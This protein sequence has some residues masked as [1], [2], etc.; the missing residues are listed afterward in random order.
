MT[1]FLHTADLH[2]NAQRRNF[3]HYLT[4]AEWLLNEIEDLATEQNCDCIVVA[5]DIFEQPNTTIAERQLLSDWLGRL[6]TPVLMI[7]GNHDARDKNIGNTCISYLSSLK[8]HLHLVHDG[9]PRIVN[10]FG[11]CWL[12]LPYHGWTD[13]EFRLIVRTM[14]WRIRRKQPDVPIV[15]ITHEAVKGAMT[16]RN[17]SIEKSDQ[18][19]LVPDLGPTY[20][21]LGDIHAPQQMLPN[22]YYCGAPYQVDFGEAAD[23]KGVLLVDTDDP[24]HPV[25]VDLDCPYPLMALHEPPAGTWPL[26]GYYTGEWVKTMP[27]HILYRPDAAEQRPEIE[28]QRSRV[29]LLH[30]LKEKLIEQHHPEDLLTATVEMG[31]AMAE[32][33]GYAT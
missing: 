12:L 20:W 2:L 4:R 23:Q 29:P 3:P 27:E 10:A 24:E 21:A 16:D 31:H 26:F 25:S 6:Q 28:I 30:R 22:A 7:S 15:A 8:L 1:R 5:G 19:T 14:V 18:I 9:D 11:C 13:Q 33:L 17:I 32:E